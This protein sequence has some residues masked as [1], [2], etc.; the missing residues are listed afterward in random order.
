MMKLQFMKRSHTVSGDENLLEGC[1]TACQEARGSNPAGVKGRNRVSKLCVL[2]LMAS[3]LMLGAGLSSCHHHDDREPV[4]PPKVEAAPNTLAGVVTN[5]SGTPVQGATVTLGT[6]SVKTDAN[7]AYVFQN[8]AQ[9]KYTV[10]AA[11]DGM[12]TASSEV[13]F[14]KASEQNL[15]W[16]VTLNRKTT[17]NLVVTDSGE[18]ASGDVQSDNIP[19]NDEGAVTITV[20][21][22]ANTVPDNTTITIAPIYSTQD[23]TGTRADDET[24]LIGANV[25]CSDPDLQLTSP[26]DVVFNLDNS[27][28]TDVKVREFDPATGSWRDVTPTVDGGKVTVKTTKFTSFGIFLPVTVTTTS[29][30]EDIVFAQDLFD[31]R[32][33]RDS[34]L[35]ENAS[36]TYKTG[37]AVNANAKNKLEG[38][39]IEYLAR[40]FGAKVTEMNGSYPLNVTL[41]VGQGI[42]L[43]G[44]QTVEAVRVASRN[45]AVTGT[46]YGSVTVTTSAFSVD[47]NGGVVGE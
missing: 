3:A 17:Q 41:A 45:T 7:G 43:K 28:V 24:M 31:N 18:D 39:L 36:F 11:A 38:L 44:T 12:Y 21:V 32:N 25:T 10:S 20:D 29:S 42:L 33:G 23:A 6:T 15:L 5:I 30:A 16:S 22:P 19:N 40:M 27:V 4:L 34:M 35:V 9:G 8:V 1:A 14:S 37:T 13:T 2:T 46:R 26:I 47:H